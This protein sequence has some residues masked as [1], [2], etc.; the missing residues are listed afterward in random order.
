[1]Q[2][3]SSTENL[4]TQYYTWQNYCCAYEVHNPNN[5]NSIALLL[6]QPIGVGLSRQFWSR[7]CQQWYAAGQRHPIY[8]PDL[9]GCGDS[10]MP[11]VAYYPIDWAEQLHYFL[12][13]VVKKPVV[14]VV[15]GALFPVA[16]EL[17]Q[18]A[19]ESNL[20]RGL[21]LS[22]PPPWPL[23]TK[24]TSDRRHKINWNIFDS[25]VGRAFFEYARSRKFLRNFSIRQLFAKAKDVDEEWVNTLKI[26]A[27]NAASR[28]AVFSFLAGF[29]RQDYKDAI[30]QISQPTLVVMGEFASSISSKGKQETPDERL[31]DYLAC[32]S[33]GRG[34]K[35]AGRNVLPY[36]ETAEF[37]KA[38]APFINA[39]GSV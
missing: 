8:N 23:I 39:I 31:A 19:K 21:V 28:H 11:H 29:W 33:K 37:V 3:G 20:I 9:L 6:I 12:Q 35:I 10:N 18:L 7:F 38:I 26:G 36:E 16:I 13:N 32:L 17:V 30:A 22:G 2:T 1:M 25:P 34:V 5:N 27:K 24:N 14:I 4:P 15:Q